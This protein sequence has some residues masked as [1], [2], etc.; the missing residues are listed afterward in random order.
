MDA[1]TREKCR[2][3]KG[4]VYLR[5]EYLN[6]GGY[7]RD[8]VYFGVGDNLYYMSDEDGLWSDYF[9]ASCRDEAIEIG[10]DTYPNAKFRK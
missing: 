1:T 10:R 6:Q 7:N 2:Q 5:R 8:G 3:F 9:R 4:V